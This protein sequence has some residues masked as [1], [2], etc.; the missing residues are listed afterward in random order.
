MASKQNRKTSA[1]TRGLGDILALVMIALAVMLAAAQ[2]SF[3]PGDLRFFN[4]PPNETTRNL[5]GM[6]GAHFAF[7]VF[8]L[9]GLAAYLVPVLLVLFALA[10]FMQWLAYL[11]RRWAWGLILLFCCMGLVEINEG[12]FQWWLNRTAMDNPGGII[13]A[14]LSRIFSVFGRMG[15]TIVFITLYAISLLYLTNFQ[16]G[17]WLR[18]L[19]V[20]FRDWRESSASEEKKLQRKARELRKQAEKLQAEAEKI[21]LGAD[22]QPVPEPMVRDLSVPQARGGRK[23][24][25]LPPPEDEPEEGVEEG[26]V[27]PAE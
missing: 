25:T 21:G 7:G 26:E 17:E 2:W 4:D 14:F 13:G 20:R 11:K 12:L 15:A 5:T 27:I 10:F 18:N 16:L 6:V 22:L 24:K 19:V 23:E 1:P 3:D 9:F 8:F